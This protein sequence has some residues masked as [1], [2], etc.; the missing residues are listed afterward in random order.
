MS[1]QSELGE[2]GP[3]CRRQIIAATAGPEVGRRIL[4]LEIT[5]DPEGRFRL[6]LRRHEL[7]IEDKAATADAILIG[8]RPN[9][10]ETLANLHLPLD[11]PIERAA[12][13]KLGD[14]SRH[15]AGDMDMHGFSPRLPRF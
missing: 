4:R 2:L 1:A 10:G 5:P 12:V 8:E 3:K 14:T 13:E 7:R 6:P 11:H 15:H 9:G